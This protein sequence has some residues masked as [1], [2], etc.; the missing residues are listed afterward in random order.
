MVKRASGSM[1]YVRACCHVLL[2]SWLTHVRFRL[3]V[4][5]KRG[6]GSMNYVRA[7]GHVLVISWRTHVRFRL[8]LM[9]KRASRSMNFVC[10]FGHVWPCCSWVGR[11]WSLPSYSD[12]WCALLCTCEPSLVSVSS[13]CMGNHPRAA[14]PSSAKPSGCA[15]HASQASSCACLCNVLARGACGLAAYFDVCGGKLWAVD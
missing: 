10:A 9:M 12:S 8:S 3:S 4:M 15:L 5:A 11:V 14:M 7:C 2:V 6:S 13:S 1:N